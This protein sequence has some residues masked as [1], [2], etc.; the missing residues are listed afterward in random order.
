MG[1]VLFEFSHENSGLEGLHFH[2]ELK[3]LKIGLPLAVSE[4]PKIERSK[5][6]KADLIHY[7]HQLC[8]KCPE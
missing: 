7:R 4:L 1:K 8:P 3:Q 6:Q 5:D 2:G